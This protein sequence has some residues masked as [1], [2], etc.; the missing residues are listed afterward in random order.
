MV[1][2]K[3]RSSRFA[4]RMMASCISTGMGT[5]QGLEASEF[6]L[7]HADLVF[8][9]IRNLRVAVLFDIIEYD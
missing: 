5:E 4:T 1:A 7:R 3:E 6:R 8:D 2:E 9:G